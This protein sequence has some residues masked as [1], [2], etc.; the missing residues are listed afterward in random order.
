[1]DDEQAAGGGRHPDADPTAEDAHAD[2][3]DRS[4]GRDPIYRALA[5]PEPGRLR[6]LDR[7]TYEPVVTAAEG[8]DAPV[9]KVRPGYLVEADLDWSTAEPTVRSLSVVRPTLYAFADGIDP[10]FEVA[11]ETWT[12][13][14]STGDSMNSRVTRN[15]D[16][17]VNGVVYVFAEQGTDG[18]GN[19]VGVGNGTD[20][21]NGGDAGSAD[22]VFEE[23]RDGAR[24]LEPLVDRV[25][26]SD[27]PVP[28]EVFV[29]R[30]P[31]GE[32]VVVTIAFRK[33][34]RFADTLRET[35]DRP[36]PSEPL[37]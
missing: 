13:A 32:F 21:G 25:N 6:L 36:R 2:E 33:G 28:R 14:R 11:R 15:T 26:D 29:L 23:F 35:Y 8:H 17:E 12:E 20:V 27:G 34:G 24:P 5:V 3:G 7:E 9:A 19:G 16:N 31:E 18:V 30:P 4:T 1:M 37:E 10:V 22:G